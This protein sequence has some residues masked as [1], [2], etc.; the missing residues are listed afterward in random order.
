[1]APRFLARL[2]KLA[3][4][5]LV[6]E[7]AGIGLIGAVELVA[8]KATKASFPAGKLV[9][10]TIAEFAEAEGVIVRPMLGDRI[11]VCPPLVIGEAEIDELFDRL[12]RGLDRGLD[13]VWREGLMAKQR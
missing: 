13:W 11:A 1:M 8:D 9:G 7:A 4:H 12:G 6:G 3:E 5:P 2:R 10:A